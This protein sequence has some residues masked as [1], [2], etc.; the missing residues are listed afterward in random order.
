MLLP[1]NS[2]SLSM[3]NITYLKPVEYR[4]TVDIAPSQLRQFV[5]V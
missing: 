2:V 1:A 3:Y 5:N 4:P